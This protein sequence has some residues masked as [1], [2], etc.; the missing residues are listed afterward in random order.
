MVDVY[1]TSLRYNYYQ[2]GCG[3]L[4]QNYHVVFD[5]GTTWDDHVEAVL[6]VEIE[7]DIASGMLGL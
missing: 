5:E 6:E 3:F 4:F 2:Q 7:V 1:Y